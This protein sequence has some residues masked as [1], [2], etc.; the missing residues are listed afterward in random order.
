MPQTPGLFDIARY[1]EAAATWEGG[2]DS[3]VYR[4]DPETLM[5]APTGALAGIPFAVKDVIDVAGMPTRFG[6]DAFGDAGPASVDA[7]VVGAVRKA[8]AIPVGKTRST[9]CAFIDPT[10][11]RNPYDTARSPGGSSS[12]SGAAV[13]AGIVPFAFGTQTAGSLCRPATYCGCASYKPGIGVLPTEGMSPLSPSFDAI[14]VIARDTGW[15]GRVFDV[16][17]SRFPVPGSDT[18]P[19]SLRVGF[20]KA[21]EQS[22][23]KSMRDLAA[24]TIGLLQDAGHEVSE[25]ASPVSF[26]DIIARHR[27]VM[28]HEAARELAPRL[29]GRIDG[30]KP[31]FRAGIEQGQTISR[32]ESDTALGWIEGERERFWDRLDGFD[33]LMAYPVPG[34]APVGLKTTGDQS[35]LTP[36]TA[37]AGPLVSLIA[38]YDRDGMPLGML[39]ASKPGSDRFLMAA[40]RGISELLPSR[41]PARLVTA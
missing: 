15:L 4:P 27:I 23:D 1:E 16:L 2:I 31:L 40:A 39:F 24:A 38:G 18:V 20:V 11:T 30:L 32:G 21:P 17:T 7:P 22:P 14:G 26:A 8:G 6:S 10:T 34:P 3:F 12:G 28:L 37:M 29:A 5:A 33:L 41:Q 36:W 35:Y 9:E 13:G 25:V 19:N